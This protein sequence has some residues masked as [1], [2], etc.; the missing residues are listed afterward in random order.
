MCLKDFTLKQ[1]KR[2]RKNLQKNQSQSQGQ[3]YNTLKGILVLFEIS[4]RLSSSTL[5]IDRS[6][7]EKVKATR[8]TK[9]L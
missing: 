1:K 9:S 4:E 2:L 7:L 6:N 5:Q 3:N 8:I